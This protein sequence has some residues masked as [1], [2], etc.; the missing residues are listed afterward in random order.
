MVRQQKG[1][2]ISSHIVCLPTSGFSIIPE[3]YD[4]TPTVAIPI[5]SSH[6]LVD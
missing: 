5:A 6:V 1:S 2:I 3:T 4:A